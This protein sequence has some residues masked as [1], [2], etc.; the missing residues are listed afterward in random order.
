M[1]TIFG[2]LLLRILMEEPYDLLWI[3]EVVWRILPA[4]VS[5][6]VM[7]VAA[8]RFQREIYWRRF[9][10]ACFAIAMVGAI[11]F[12]AAAI[13]PDLNSDFNPLFSGSDFGALLYMAVILVLVPFIQLSALV[14]AVLKDKSSKITRHWSHW[15]GVVTWI[16]LLAGHNL[17]RLYTLIPLYFG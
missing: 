14:V 17:V 2:S 8:R 1:S 10:Y 5:A 4:F 7:F 11:W 6:G 16:A 3:H 9:F 15:C 13:F 12:S